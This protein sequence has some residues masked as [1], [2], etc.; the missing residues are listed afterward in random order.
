M[1]LGVDGGGVVPGLGVDTSAVPVRGQ[2]RHRRHH[3]R[4]DN[5][6]PRTAESG[7][8]TRPSRGTRT[9]GKPVADQPQEQSQEQ[10]QEQQQEQSDEQQRDPGLEQQQEPG[11]E[12]QQGQ[13]AQDP[14]RQRHRR[15]DRHRS[16]RDGNDD[17]GRQQGEGRSRDE[18]RSRSRSRGVSRSRGG[19]GDVAAPATSAA[20]G[21]DAA[22]SG[23]EVS[24]APS[25][26]DGTSNAAGNTQ[27]A[28]RGGVRV[29]SKAG[30]Y[31]PV[32]ASVL[33]EPDSDGAA[34]AAKTDL[35]RAALK[36]SGQKRGLAVRIAEPDKSG[37]TTAAAKPSGG[38]GGGN[39]SG[40]GSG[41]VAAKGT[42]GRRGG[43]AGA[44]AVAPTQVKKRSP[45]KSA[46]KAVAHVATA[47]RTMKRV[48]DD[49]PLVYEDKVEWVTAAGKQGKF[50][51]IVRRRLRLTPEQIEELQRA[52]QVDDA[53][54]AKFERA[55]QREAKS[56]Q[57]S[58][59]AVRGA[60]TA[61]SRRGSVSGDAS[62]AVASGGGVDNDGDSTTASA[63]A[64]S[65]RG[66]GNANARRG[67]FSGSGA[68]A[69]AAAAAAAA[70]S[71]PPLSGG[72]GGGA[73]AAAAAAAGARRASFV[74][75]LPGSVAGLGDA[76]NADTGDDAANDALSSSLRGGS[77]V[78]PDV[79]VVG[80]RVTPATPDTRQRRRSGAFATADETAAIAEAVAAAAAVAAA[81]GG[82]DTGSGGGVAA[83]RS[84]GRRQSLSGPSA[85]AETGPKLSRRGSTSTVPFAAAR[86]GSSDG[87][88]SAAV[89]DDAAG[90]GGAPWKP[91]DMWTETQ[92]VVGAT[93][94]VEER[95]ALI[96][97]RTGPLAGSA[98]RRSAS[99]RP[100]R[101]SGTAPDADQPETVLLVL[102]SDSEG[103]DDSGV[104]SGI[105][106]RQGRRRRVVALADQRPQTGVSKVPVF[107][108]RGTG[109]G[110]TRGP[111]VVGKGDEADPNN[112]GGGDA[113]NSAGSRQG[114]GSRRQQQQQ[115]VAVFVPGRVVSAGV[116]ARSGLARGE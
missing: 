11:L 69:A 85:E 64:G 87:A 81:H 96:L 114:S 104:G 16:P 76:A 71:T 10:R 38:D 67:S 24:T 47:T 13:Q 58:A 95:S 86:D 106:G 20:G 79:T 107:L 44:D 88:P 66:H 45:G 105:A 60:S 93:G 103:E 112:A 14:S 5:A 113:A 72:G 4:S 52:L 43:A 29:G 41:T 99:N 78:P 22:A 56:R 115:S 57:S 40:N 48:R 31:K 21:G 90:D 32:Q 101:E 33:D 17:G 18:S 34:G 49:G 30:G 108:K 62:A 26:D 1:V 37:G 98:K 91:F 82:D 63:T 65:S 110:G 55:K 2:S 23:V 94:Q 97:R 6:K 100:F 28:Q 27:D 35:P 75:R 36:S 15:R 9:A 42:K 19:P 80:T 8:E 54:A 84:G 73:V 89:D 70:Q 3:R 111:A 12:Q 74:G 68:G 92:T 83:V 7:D 46:A 61:N 109:T 39:G 116:K 50:K 59:G 102:S 77:S 53:A 51:A 25:V